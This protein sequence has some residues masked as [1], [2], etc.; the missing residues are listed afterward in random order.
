MHRLD[1]AGAAKLETHFEGSVHLLGLL[2]GIAR[3]LLAAGAAE[4]ETHFEGGVRLLGLLA[5][6][7]RQFLG[8]DVLK[9]GKRPYV[10][11]HT[12]LLLVTRSGKDVC[13][14]VICA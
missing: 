13:V 7:A 3:Q 9:K 5:G 8:E 6:I 12:L 14:E 10:R 4:L 2:A 1:A 11:K